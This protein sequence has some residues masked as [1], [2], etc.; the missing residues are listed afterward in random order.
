MVPLVSDLVLGTLQVA[1]L[2]PFDPSRVDL[3]PLETLASHT[4]RA[5]TGLRQVEEIR[6]LNQTQEQHAQELARS[7]LALREQTRILQSVLDCMGDGVVVAD[8][9][10]R[11]LVFNPAAARILGHGRSD[12]G[13]HEWSRHYEIFRCPTARSRIPLTIFRWFVQFVA[14]LSIKPSCTS[15]IPAATMAPGSSSRA[16][17]CATNTARSRAEWSSFTT[18]PGGRKRSED[19]LP[20]Y[21]TTRVLAEATRP[22]NPSRRFSR[23]S[24]SVSTGTWERSGE[25]I[26]PPSDC[27]AGRS[28]DRPAC[29][30]FALEAVNH[31]MA[32]QRGVGFTGRV[33]DSAE[34]EWISDITADSS[35]L[36]RS[37]AQADGFRTA[38]AVPI[39]LRGECLG[40]LEFFALVP[41]PTDLGAS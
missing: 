36:R 23:R 26:R 34:P 35:F 5:L 6:R 29:A 18:S 32:M 37:A 12:A 39:L 4:A 24:V 9:N 17:L 10:A 14:S 3:R 30:M 20:Q 8:S 13:A 27:A 19:S 38:F 41:R 28:G 33:W 15:P 11:F 7:E 16:D 40:V 25:S 22:P 2:R 1:S 21:E 31:E